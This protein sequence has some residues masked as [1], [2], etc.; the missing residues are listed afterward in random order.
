MDGAKIVT[1]HQMALGAEVE[2]PVLFV[3]EPDRADAAPS[4]GQPERCRHVGKAAAVVA[5]ERVRP[6]AE[7]HEQVQ[8][9]VGV[10]VDLVRECDRIKPEVGDL[11]RLVHARCA[12][13]ARRF[14]L[15]APAAR[16]PDIGR[17]V[18][19]DRRRHRA[20]HCPRHHRGA[21]RPPGPRPASGR[22]VSG[23]G[24]R[25]R[26]GARAARAREG[27][28]RGVH[29]GRGS[30]RQHEGPWARGGRASLRQRGA[31]SP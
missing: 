17:V 1:V 12:V 7:R 15:V 4:V 16:R 9:I 27:G 28:R 11:S 20:A 25:D 29:G 13:M 30:G 14:P 24:G 26:G 18:E 31:G 10:D 2:V 19:A 5:V 8:V 23:L 3:V 21:D 6:V 22:P